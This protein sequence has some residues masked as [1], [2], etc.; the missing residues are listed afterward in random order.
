MLARVAKEMYDREECRVLCSD[1]VQEFGVV[2]GVHV[3]CAVMR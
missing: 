2:Q 1:V 3:V